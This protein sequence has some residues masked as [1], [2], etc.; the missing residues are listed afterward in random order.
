[1]FALPG[2]L[3]AV[4]VCQAALNIVVLLLFALLAVSSYQHFVTSRSLS[5]LGILAINTLFLSLFLTRRDAKAETP[6]LRLW[7]LGMAGTALPLLLRPSGGPGFIGFGTVLQLAGIALV[8]CALLSLRRS[9]AVVPGNRGIRDGGLY[10]IVRHPIYI[11][12]LLAL[13]GAVLV[14][15][16][17]A[18][19]MIWVCECGLQFARAHA[20][21]EFLSSDPAYRAYRER[22]R[23]RLIPGMI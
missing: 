2:S 23:F 9:F 20:E 13:L 7:L 14:S 17:L 3:S 5:S 4:R 19:W 21:E 10:R 8:A 6:S 1:M 12:E 18:N 22:V 15:P 16:T 11:S